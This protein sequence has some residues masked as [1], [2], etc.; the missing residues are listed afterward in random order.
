MNFHALVAIPVCGR[1]HGNTAFRKVL[2]FA[3]RFVENVVGED[4]FGSVYL[5]CL[6]V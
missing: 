6:E 4:V 2:F 3:D 1:I 5:I